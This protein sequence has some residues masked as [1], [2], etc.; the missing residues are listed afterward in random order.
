MTKE[1]RNIDGERP[2]RF[3]A[4]IRVSTEAQ[5]RQGESLRTQRKQLEQVV[6]SLG[7]QVL[8]WYGGQEHATPDCERKELDR[9]MGD[10]IAEKFDAVIVT[11]TSRWSRDNLR[12][13]ECLKIF[14]TH[15]IRFFASTLEYDL[16]QPEQNFVLCMGVEISEFFARQQTHKSLINRIERAKRGY[17]SSGGKPYGRKWDKQEEKWSVIP[18]AKTKIEAIAGEYLEEG[19]GFVELGRR[20]GM[21][22]SN[23]WKIL[24]RRSGTT[25]PQR[26]QKEEFDI[27]E[28]V[29]TPVPSLLDDEVIARVKEKSEARRT[30]DRGPIKN[31]YLLSRVIYD[32]HTGHALTGCTHKGNRYYRPYRGEQHRYRLN[33]E[34]IERAV[35]SQLSDCISDTDSFRS[36]VYDSDTKNEAADGLRDKKAGLEKRLKQLETEHTKMTNR[37]LKLDGIDLDTFLEK[38]RPTMEEVQSDLKKTKAEI[39]SIDTYLSS[40]ATEQEIEAERIRLVNEIRLSIDVERMRQENEIRFAINYLPYE[41]KRRLIGLIF[42]GKGRDVRGHKYGIHIDC[43]GGSPKRYKWT[44]YAR[45]IGST[46]WVEG[47]EAIPHPEYDPDLHEDENEELINEAAKMVVQNAKTPFARPWP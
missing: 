40:L 18:E 20:H 43:L 1:Q 8:N 44:A 32:A 31:R 33:A 38:M 2:L 16:T 6:A 19:I 42:G 46:G 26:F 28:T 27:D 5:E 24:I 23:L 36:A 15:G 17:P 13:K 30:W 45:F 29:L 41:D 34:A 35:I 12:N 39:R 7:G 9:L 22:P 4:L 11:D 14:Q 25:W 10:A 47:T 3:A 37:I 21:D